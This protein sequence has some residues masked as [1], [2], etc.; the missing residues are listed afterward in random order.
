MNIK[1]VLVVVATVMSFVA[2][3]GG[4]STVVSEEKKSRLKQTEQNIT[5][6]KYD[7]GYYQV[8]QERKYEQG[9][10]VLRD[11]VTGLEWQ[12]TNETGDSDTLFDWA[13]AQS[14]CSTL[15]LNGEDDW[16]LPTVY[17]LKSLVVYNKKYPAMTNSFKHIIADFE[18]SFN[19]EYWSSTLDASDST[20]AW[21]VG[22][23]YGDDRIYPIYN[24]AKVRCV[25]GKDRNTTIYERDET[26]GIVA[27]T[28]ANLIWQ[29]N[30]RENNN[31]V[32][33]ASYADALSYCETLTLGRKDDWRLPNINE[34]YSLVDKTKIYPS[35]N[36]IFKKVV[37]SYYWSST[38][39]I[40]YPENKWGI[41]FDFGDDGS[42]FNSQS[43]EH[44]VRCVRG[45]K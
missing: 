37:A 25:R 24:W 1:I 36:P 26:L 23:F 33:K 32:K 6:F 20:L 38:S 22:S 9:D 42:W 12:D 15:A 16:R 2:C 21:A 4:G 41:G 28:I 29:D 39:D 40:E 19:D 18:D 17:E 11:V 7:D 5:F 45:G 35:I 43:D 44:Y 34:L 30:Y 13:E 10:E 3:G 14:Y 31:S 27:D 8:G